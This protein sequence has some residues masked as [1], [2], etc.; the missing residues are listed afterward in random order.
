[1]PASVR[2][3]LLSEPA[4]S[5]PSFVSDGNADLQLIY[6]PEVLE[7]TG[8]SFPS[9]WERIRRNQFPAPRMMGTRTV[10]LRS[11][12]VA[13]LQGLPKRQYLPPPDEEKREHAMAARRLA[14][15][16]RR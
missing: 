7:L 9:L 1:M 13:W 14:R 8:L 3:R 10:W 11:E 2:P 4:T 5:E 16:T 12:I 6:K 15:K